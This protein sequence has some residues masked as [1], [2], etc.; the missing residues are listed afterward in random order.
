MKATASELVT[1]CDAL[2]GLANRRGFIRAVTALIDEHPDTS[3]VLV[4]GDIDR[5][6]VFNDRF[7]TEAGD[8]LLAG[9]GAMME[10]MLPAPSVAARVRADHFVCCVPRDLY[11]PDRALAV[12]DGW[13]KAYP[14]D[15]AFFVRLGLYGIDDPTLDVSLMTDRALLALRAAKTGAHASKF[16][17]YD[18]S[19]RDRVLKEQ[20]LV[21]EMATALET[22]QFELYFQPQYQFTTGKLVGAEV[23]SRWNHPEKGLISPLEF[24]PV[25]ERTGVI[26]DLDY[27]VWAEACRCLRTWL[28]AAGPGNEAQV[29]RL[30]VN[31][32]RADVYR[33]DLCDYLVGLIA[34]YDIPIDLLHVEITEGAYVENPLQLA[35]AVTRLQ[36][37]GFTVEMDDFGSGYSSLNALKDVPVDV[38]KLDLRFLDARNDTRG[39][40]ILASVVRMAHWLDLPVIAEGVESESQA[41]FLSSV[42]CDVM[43]GFWFSRP[44]DRATFEQVLEQAQRGTLPHGGMSCMQGDFAKL[45]DAESSVALVFNSYVGAAALVECDSSQ[46]EV[47][48]A[49]DEFLALLGLPFDRLARSVGELFG[50]L[51]EEDRANFADALTSAK[52][53]AHTGECELC[54]HGARDDYWIHVQM[55]LLSKAGDVSSL[56]LTIYEINEL[57][58]LRSKLQAAMETMPN[59]MGFYLIED[60]VAKLLDCN[61]AAANLVG[62]T[63]D[64]YTAVCANDPLA[65]V[66]SEDRN[67]VRSIVND[68]RTGV[69]RAEGTIRALHVD[70]TERWLSL[71][72]SLMH[73]GANTLYLVVALLD[74]TKDKEKDLQY[75]RLAEQQQQ[76]YETVPCGI[77]RYTVEGDLHISSANRA[78]W[79][80]LGCATYEEFLAYIGDDVFSPFDEKGH[81]LMRRLT[82]RLRAGA[83]PV[84]FSARLMRVD[85]SDAWIEGVCALATTSDGESIVQSAFNDVTDERRESHKRELQRFTSVLCSAYNEIF[86]FDVVR[87]TFLLCFS[88]IFPVEHAQ[89][90]PVESAM[91]RW[92]NHVPDPAD[93]EAIR[94]IIERCRREPLDEPLSYAYRCLSP[95]G[96]AWN[97]STFMRVSETSVLCCNNDVSER[98]DAEDARLAKRVNDIVENLPTGIGVYDLDA[99]GVHLRYVSDTL[100]ALMDVEV[101]NEDII[102]MSSAIVSPEEAR[103]FIEQYDERWSSFSVE[104]EL[105]HQGEPFMARVQGRTVPRGDGVIRMYTVV[106]DV[107]DEARER[108][109]RAWQNERYRMLSELTHSISFDYNSESDTVLLYIDRTGSGMEAQVIPEYL[110][111]LSNTR[112]GVVHP[113]SM[114]AVRAMFERARA[115]TKNEIIEYRADYYDTGYQWYRANLFVAHDEGGA[116]HLVGLIENIQAERELRV[117]A[118]HDAITGLSNNAST[119]SLI[120]AALSD[121]HVCARS[122]CAVIDLDD[123]KNVNDTFGHLRGDELLQQVGI[124][125]RSNCREHD[126]VGRVGGDEFVVFLKNINLEVAAR[127]LAHM[128]RSVAHIALMGKPGESFSPTLSIGATPTHA[129]DA[130][131]RDVFARADEALYQ[132]KHAGK[133]RL[134][135]RR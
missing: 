110:E 14:V 61:E 92:F 126:V 60:D 30:S 105:V 129:G 43:Q 94:A 116:W 55:R 49:N 59:G 88:S 81:A 74:V 13:L 5:F 103:T 2:T 108:R 3:F 122:V 114:D 90:V 95:E 112:E 64:E 58:A 96:F 19:M 86:E 69:T 8:R 115:G 15:F 27:Y 4:Y 77:V 134:R 50:E 78:A 10:R 99:E 28:D 70:G 12:L 29:P 80:L 41:R 127:K 46:C 7:G 84:S 21:G 6:K 66:V 38:M 56:L 9:V 72:A 45:W 23:L 120:D 22:G 98:V 131:Y 119:R 132:A 20:E 82:D 57:Q 52:G 102:S 37:A 68:L 39:G 26:S 16:V 101:G 89:P 100:Y 91:E 63:R 104:R 18:E 54:I 11:D 97:E 85:G 65:L 42:G 31:L 123:F 83:P 130:A 106:T 121:P 128:K 113:D 40:V 51:S 44:V 25:F 36:Q 109:E 33:E 93:H 107:T 32:S 1:E 111:T 17:W 76:L 73:R 125:L 53:E 71:S 47:V 24:I 135:I 118:E 48:R 133:N 34:Q 87:G 117:L 75:R 124:I 79:S 62:M 67:V 35:G